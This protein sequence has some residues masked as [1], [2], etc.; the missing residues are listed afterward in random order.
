MINW[1]ISRNDCLIE[2]KKCG[3]DQSEIDSHFWSM[4]LLE[5]RLRNRTSDQ[6]VWPVAGIWE[7]RDRR[8]CITFRGNLYHSWLTNTTYHSFVWAV[9]YFALSPWYANYKLPNKRCV[10]DVDPFNRNAHY[11]RVKIYLHYAILRHFSQCMYVQL[12][13]IILNL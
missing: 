3:I 12:A 8:C 6:H 9:R 2:Y 10:C 13:P 11:L 5:V 7:R 4:S 1:L